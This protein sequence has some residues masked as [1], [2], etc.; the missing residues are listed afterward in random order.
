MEKMRQIGVKT[1]NATAPDLMKEAGKFAGCKMEITEGAAFFSLDGRNA[2]F[3]EPNQKI[4]ALN[5]MAAYIWCRLEEGQTPEMISAELIR[6]GVDRRL[7]ERYVHQAL[8]S[9]LRLGLLKVER[10][11]TREVAEAGHSIGVRLGK[12]KVAIHVFSD[13]LARRLTPL[14][15]NHPVPVEECD[16]VFHVAEIDRLI[17]VFHNESHVICCT[18][19]ELAPLLKAYVTEQI[20]SRSAP[21]V[22]FHAACM[23]RGGKSILIS[24]APGAGKT[25]LSMNLM[26]AGF[27][28]GGDDIVLI[29]PEGD[30]AAVPFAPTVKSGAWDIVGKIYPELFDAP[31]YRRPDG[32]RV[33]YLL[34][35]LA[36]RNISYPVR[37]IVFI[38]RK[39]G[40]TPKLNPL[41]R[42]DAMRRLMEGSFSPGGKL[43]QASCQAIKRTLA[44]SNSFELTYAD[45]ADATQAIT[46]LCND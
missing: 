26:S 28:Y 2:I 45:V 19:S 33:R 31:I 7:A 17:H 15:G 27:E 21:D 18:A 41:G 24:G 34:P 25:T 13:P 32:K 5:H 6:T 29:T 10:L 1:E 8:R 11:G 3:S 12:L 14:F 9:W 44:N 39:S 43:T 16:D 4:Y 20:V 37:W 23:V 42:F 30:V 36:A 40:G 22:L 38:Q 46:G 35:A